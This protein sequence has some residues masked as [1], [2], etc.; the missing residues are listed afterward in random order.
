MLAKLFSNISQSTM[1]LR[2]ARPNAWTRG[3]PLRRFPL[4]P[5]DFR[6]G[7]MAQLDAECVITEFVADIGSDTD[8]VT[9]FFKAGTM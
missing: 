8:E 3:N 7:I 5:S 2:V 4:H 1:K 9:V 6:A